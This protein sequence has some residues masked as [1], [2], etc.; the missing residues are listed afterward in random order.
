ME[1]VVLCGVNIDT[2]KKKV[3]AQGAVFE[4]EGFGFGIITVDVTKLDGIFSISEIEYIELPKTLFSSFQGSNEA[5]CI[6]KVW[7]SYKLTGEGVTI[8]FLDSGIDYLHPAFLDDL[9]NTRIRYIYDLSSGGKVWDEQKINEALKSKNPIEVVPE[10]DELGHGTFVAGVACAGGNIDKRYYGAAYKSSIIMVK[11]TQQGK[12]NYAKST[13]LIRGIKFLIDKAREIGSP[14]VINLSFSTNDGAHDGTSLLEKYI[15]TVSAL[16]RISFVV[17]AGNEGDRGHHEGGILRNNEKIEFNIGGGEKTLFLQFYKGILDDISIEIKDAAANSTGVIN[18][19]EK[20]FEAN[21]GAAKLFFYATGARPFGIYGEV[22]ITIVSENGFLQEGIW[23]ININSNELGQ[24]SQ[25]DIWMPVAEGLNAATR[26]LNPNPYNTLG[27]PATVL[28]VFSAGS[29]NY[30]TD[31]LSSFSGRGERNNIFVKPDI[32]SP[33]ENIESTLSGGGYD[34]LSGTSFSAPILSGCCAIMMQWGFVQ[35]NDPYMYGQRLKYYLIKGAR[36]NKTNINYPDASWGYGELCLEGGLNIAIKM[37]LGRKR[38]DMNNNLDSKSFKANNSRNKVKHDNKH[39]RKTK[40][41]RQSCPES[42]YVEDN[43]MNFIVEYDGDIQAAL[44]KIPSACAFVLD[45]NYAVVSV[46]ETNADEVLNSIKE[47]VYREANALYTLNTFSPLSAANIIKFHDNPYLTLRGE[48]VILGMVD[49][50][51]D[52]LN[53]EFMYEDDTTRIASIWDMT[54]KDSNPPGSFKFGS[55]YTREQINIAIKAK[56]EN[57]DP[58]AIVPSKDEIGHGTK[59]ACIIGGRGRNKDLTG[60]A[61]DSEFA[62]VK[63]KPS[64]AAVLRYE[65]VDK[66]S[67]PVYDSTLVTLAIKYLYELGKKLNKPV[68]IYIPVGTNKGAH[69]GS[70]ILE[71]YIDSISKTRG[72]AVVSGTGNQGISETHLRDVIEKTNDKKIIELKAGAGQKNLSFQI[73][74]RKPDKISIGIVSPSG[75]VVEKIPAKLNQSENLKFI[76]EGSTLNVKYYLTE[77][78]TGDEL[79]SVRINDIKPG[80]WRF[81]LYGDYIV[82]GQFDAYLPQRE[83]ISD[84]TKFLSPNQYTTLMVPSTGKLIISGAY[85]NQDNNTVIAASGRGYT[86]DDRIKPDIAA[87]G[88]NVL[89]VNPGGSLSILNGSSAGSAVLTGAVALLLEWG[90][91]DGNDTTMYSTKIITYLARGAKKRPG[92]IYPNTEWGYGML[93]LNMVFENLRTIDEKYSSRDSNI[94][95]HYKSDENTDGNDD[96]IFIRIP[97]NFMNTCLY[98]KSFRSVEYNKLIL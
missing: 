61:P 2:V 6:P 23:S 49:T 79:I 27:I 48:G 90:I 25:Y 9:G 91:V 50:G 70:S 3:T 33:G 12:L 63:M 93:D 81:T 15:E 92:D 77:E 5:S 68:V 43:H 28:N 30:E 78:V 1:L 17:S 44:K 58:Y 41:V 87:G 32:C 31:S 69:D 73:W 60:A 66:P 85:Y 62:V 84:D 21:V 39:H 94:N 13:Q 53:T 57:K 38:I 46:P 52:Y 10:T 74:A 86:R 4:D 59:A 76:F 26:F 14:L 98:K 89:T 82:N 72:I 40:R 35:N 64:N 19:S 45:E 88:Y 34:V 95:E 7:D 51:I 54:I 11:M 97:S 24:N 22:V 8:G 96:K 83:L 18:V 71:R 16:E 75:E 47:I 29:Y 65:G 36:R 20:Y 42:L 67:V 80:I 55:E 56:K 37:S